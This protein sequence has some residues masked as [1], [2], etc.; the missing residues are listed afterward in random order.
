M[1]LDLP[2]GTADDSMPNAVNCVLSLVR[3]TFMVDFEEFKFLIREKGVAQFGISRAAG[4][5]RAATAM[6]QLMNNRQL[7]DDI[8]TADSIILNITGSNDIQFE[9]VKWI[10]ETIQSKIKPEANL[11]FGTVIDEEN[12]DSLL[13]AV[14]A[15]G[16]VHRKQKITHTLWTITG[17]KL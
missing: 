9:E 6:D 4:K 8:G 15:V 1:Q 14:V 7:V 10:V 12:Q 2:L 13:L 16:T 5:N 3:A 11:I 17:N